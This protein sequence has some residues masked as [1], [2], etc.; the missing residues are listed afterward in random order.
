MTLVTRFAAG[1]CTLPRRVFDLS[2]A[3]ARTLGKPVD[4]SAYIE[5]DRSRTPPP[6]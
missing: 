5:S 2:A 3:K 6:F 4:I 1:G